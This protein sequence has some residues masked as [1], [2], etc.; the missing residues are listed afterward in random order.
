[1]SLQAISWALKVGDLRSTE[2]FVLVCMC[3]YA[4]ENGFCYPSIAALSDDTAQNR[5]TV[6]ANIKSLVLAGLIGDTGKRVGA[7]KQ[8]IVY[9]VNNPKN[10]TNKESQNRNSS[11]NGTVPILDGNSTVLPPKQSQ[12]RYTD[13]KG[14]IRN[15][16]DTHTPKKSKT[17]KSSIPEDFDLTD[18]RKQYAEKHLPAVDAAALMA[19]FRSTSKAKGWK[20]ADWDQHY[21]TLVRHWAPNSG[22]WASGQYPKKPNGLTQVMPDG[23]EVRW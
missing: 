20:Y 5:K 2:K 16:R 23:T 7:T 17:R 9:K 18:E 11:E 4:D 21:Q 22:H 19:V 13:P 12:K 3:N 14:S 6:I 10:G 15:R 8:I 1:M